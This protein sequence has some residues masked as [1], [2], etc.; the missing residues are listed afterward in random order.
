MLKLGTQVPWHF[1]CEQ[2]EDW[3]FMSVSLRLA[4]HLHPACKTEVTVKVYLWMSLNTCS[5]H[6]SYC[7]QILLY[8]AVHHNHCRLVSQR[9]FGICIPKGSSSWASRAVLE[10]TCCSLHHSVNTAY[11]CP[12]YPNQGSHSNY[13]HTG[14]FGQI[15]KFFSEISPGL[16]YSSKSCF[17]AGLLQTFTLLP[18]KIIQIV[19]YF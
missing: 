18:V 4:Y 11:W 17:W 6:P 19:N 3:P 12:V 15:Y 14:T 9:N 16:V 8:S 13:F 1:L 2:L 10:R 5:S 7:C